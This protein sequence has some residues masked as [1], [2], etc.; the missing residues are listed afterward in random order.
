MALEK[1][2]EAIITAIPYIKAVLREEA[3]ITI[4]DAAQYLYYSPSVDLN[5]HHQA[6][7]PL[8]ED[9]KQFKQVNQ[10]G[11]TVVKVPKEE[12]GVPFDSISIPIKDDAGN[13][14]GGMCSYDS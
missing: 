1:K 4:F 7:D 9:Y 10:E 12:F 14:I 2:I 13:L 8:P 3:M 6:G 5:F 11:V